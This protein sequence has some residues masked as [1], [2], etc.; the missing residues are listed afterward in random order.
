MKRWR[1]LRWLVLGICVCGCGEPVAHDSSTGGQE[2]DGGA[3]LEP[4][5]HE[6]AV[7]RLMR[8]LIAEFYKEEAQARDGAQQEILAQWEFWTESDLQELDRAAAVGD[9]EVATRAESTAVLVRR[10]RDL[11]SDL[12]T[13]VEKRYSEDPAEQAMEVMRHAAAA[14]Y[15][16]RASENQMRAV[17]AFISNSDRPSGDIVC[18]LVLQYRVRPWLDLVRPFLDPKQAVPDAVTVVGLVGDRSDAPYLRELL[19]SPDAKVRGEAAGSLGVVG[20]RSDV[21]RLEALLRDGED[22]VRRRAC[23]GLATLGDPSAGSRLI[24]LLGDSESGVRQA[25]IDAIQKLKPQGIVDRLI[26]FL[27]DGDRSIATK[28]QSTVHA[29]FPREDVQG[30]L[31]LLRADLH[32]DYFETDLL[33]A[34]SR[35]GGLMELVKLICDS[36][37]DVRHSAIYA[38]TDLRDR[39]ESLPDEVHVMIKNLLGS[40]DRSLRYDGVMACAWLQLQKATSDLLPLFQDSDPDVRKFAVGVFLELTPQIAPELVE[41]ILRTESMGIRTMVMETVGLRGRREYIPRARTMLS[42]SVPEERKAA[43]NYLDS[44]DAREA[45]EEIRRIVT[46]RDEQ[47]LS[48]ACNLLARWGSRQDADLL[49]PIMSKSSNNGAKEA[50][51]AAIA[52][53]SDSGYPLLY[54]LMNDGHPSGVND[55]LDTED[56]RFAITVF[57]FLDRPARLELAKWP[58]AWL[59]TVLWTDLT[60][61]PADAR[62]ELERR[63]INLA[64][65]PDREAAS[66]A[67]VVKIRLGL[68]SASEELDAV[69]DLWA[70]GSVANMQRYLADSLASVHE[71]DTWRVVTRMRILSR[72][73][74]T[75]DDLRAILRE[76]DVRLEGDG[77]KFWGCF[78]KGSRVS[79]LT[80]IRRIIIG[81]LSKYITVGPGVVRYRQMDECRT[82]WIER[83]SRAR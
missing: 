21:S 41:E 48:D 66:S 42:S 50:A 60:N 8:E 46:A 77:I 1:F 79:L 12:L 29:L 13:L 73:L 57:D 43:F 19:G 78:A 63:V 15:S 81:G 30:Y 56:G 20:D 7:G 25:A 62:R 9:A 75:V 69:E 68:S 27:S 23:D 83:L 35:R 31:R 58:W 6:A 24:E 80:L 10:R 37:S 17:L 36:D 51:I 52:L 67:R 55:L 11:G 72:D 26:P 45:V 64:T 38:L 33:V 53:G 22:L 47:L 18:H 2:H 76:D 3:Q 71:P 65:F 28:V 54:Q 70:P 4:P 61:W 40:P 14:W 39:G 74:I 49:I 34:W 82:Y 32:E 44:V 59:R 16:G 5:T